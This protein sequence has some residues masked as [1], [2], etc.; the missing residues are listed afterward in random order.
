[1]DEVKDTKPWALTWCDDVSVEGPQHFRLGDVQ[2]L[3][4]GIKRQEVASSAV[5]G[6][7]QKQPGLLH[8]IRCSEAELYSPPASL[9]FF[10][11]QPE[12][13]II[14]R[15]CPY[16]SQ[17]KDGGPLRVGW[18]PSSV[19]ASITA[20]NV[21]DMEFLVT[22][23]SGPQALVPPGPWLMWLE[24]LGQLQGS[25]QGQTGEAQNS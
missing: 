5:W 9:F 17:L 16:G 19:P 8:L 23:A 2:S 10:E 7:I 4:S 22:N 11:V 21:R 3:C 13:P 6:K 24:P 18:V 25:P 15:S 20:E 14:T 1:M 12:N